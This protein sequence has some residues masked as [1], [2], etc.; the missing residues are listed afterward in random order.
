MYP[1]QWL[2]SLNFVQ[3]ESKY[4]KKYLIYV[5]QKTKG[6]KKKLFLFHY[7]FV[8]TKKNVLGGNLISYSKIEN[9]ISKFFCP[10]SEIMTSV[11]LV[12]MTDIL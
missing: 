7:N 9:C 5:V 4:L 2:N 12:G 1:S 3:S 11:V 8:I 6:F 10:N